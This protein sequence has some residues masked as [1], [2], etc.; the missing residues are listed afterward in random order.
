[1]AAAL[2]DSFAFSPLIGVIGVMA[3][4][5]V[6]GVLAAFE[7]H[8]A[9]IVVHPELHPTGHSPPRSWPSWPARCSAR[10]G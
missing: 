3:D 9:H 2:E 4:K 1:M 5:E 7:P 10:T 6:E 8:L